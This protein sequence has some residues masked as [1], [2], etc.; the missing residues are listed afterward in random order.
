MQADFH[1]M[2]FEDNSFDHCYSIEACCHSPDRHGR[3]VEDSRPEASANSP[4][5]TPRQRQIELR[6]ATRLGQPRPTSRSVLA[7]RPHTGLLL[8]TGAMSTGRSCDASSLGAPSSRTS[9]AWCAAR[10]R[11]PF[12]PRAPTPASRCRPRRAAP[13]AA[14]CPLPRRAAPRPPPR[15]AHSVLRAAAAQTDQHDPKCEAH[16]YSKKMIEE[17]DGLPDIIHTKVRP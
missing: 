16:L 13:A 15:C 7:G 11:T 1:K 8:H 3:H 6:A 4:S 10:P 17:G 5:G 2:P 12:T 9:G 14:P